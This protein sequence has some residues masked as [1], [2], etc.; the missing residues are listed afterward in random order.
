MGDR[1]AV[2]R[3]WIDLQRRVL[4]DL[5]RHPSGRINRHDLVVVAMDDQGRH[6]DLLQ[7]LGVVDLGELMDAVELSL[8]PPII[9]CSQ[10][11]SRTPSDKV[12]PGRL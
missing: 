1:Q 5:R 3:A 4:D 8:Q 9:P 2:R 7:I 10:K 6:V 12:A 11:E